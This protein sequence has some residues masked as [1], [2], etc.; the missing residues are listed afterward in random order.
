WSGRN[1]REKIGTHVAFDEEFDISP[2]C[3][4]APEV[5]RYR[6]HSVVVH[7]GAGFR[8]GHYTTYSYNIHAASWLHCNDSRVQLVP[9]EEVLASQAYIL[10]YTREL[11]PVSL[12]DMPELTKIASGTDTLS[13]IS[14]IPDFD[15]ETLETLKR[16]SQG[17]TEQAV[18]EEVSIS[19]H[20]DPT[21]VKKL[22]SVSSLPGQGLKR[23]A[24]LPH[25]EQLSPA[26]LIKANSDSL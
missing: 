22:S 25:S 26:K 24:S 6:L 16:L 4:T 1:N 7:H 20:R 15:Q 2:F 10:F 8:S 12:D 5:S 17:E 18:D 14:T 3:Q 19:F 13:T 23:T 9:L 21:L 11:T